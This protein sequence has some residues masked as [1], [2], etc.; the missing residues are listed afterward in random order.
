LFDFDGPQDLDVMQFHHAT[1]M[2][3]D[4]LSSRQDHR[5]HP[6]PHFFAVNLIFLEPEH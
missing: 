1:V 3:W 2:S 4:R 6:S 5:T